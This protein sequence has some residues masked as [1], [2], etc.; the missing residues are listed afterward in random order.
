[1]F[2][3]I[4]PRY[5]FLNRVLSLGL[6]QFWRRK[7]VRALDLAPRARLLD[8]CCGTGDLALAFARKGCRAV[9]I[10]FS[11]PM[12]PLGRAKARRRGMRLPF[13]QGDAMDLPLASGSF[14]GASVAFGLRNLEDPSRGLRELNRI[15]RPGGRLAIL[16]FFRIEGSLWGPLFR[17]YFHVLLPRL[18]R[19]TRVARKGA[20]S[21]LPSSVDA[22]ASAGTFRTW[23]SAAG[24]DLLSE[25]KL[26]GGVAR[27]LILRKPESGPPA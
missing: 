2:S 24:F 14:D 20:Y 9:G 16:E 18:A 21:Y 13:L 17:F 7:A 23:T 10:D 25:K 11:G 3:H 6:D 8:V 5:D 22:F 27:L 26:A 4:A 12:L 1:M 15:L 19:F